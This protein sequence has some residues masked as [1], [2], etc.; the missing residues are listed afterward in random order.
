MQ[1]VPPPTAMVQGTGKYE[2]KSPSGVF[3]ATTID[4][5]VFTFK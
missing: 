5:R 1:G 3:Y 4:G 2:T